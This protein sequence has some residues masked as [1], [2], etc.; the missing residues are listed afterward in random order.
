MVSTLVGDSIVTATRKL[1]DDLELQEYLS[2]TTALHGLTRTAIKFAEI[3]DGREVGHSVR[4]I[5]AQYGSDYL[6]VIGVAASVAAVIKVLSIAIKRMAEAS[7][8]PAERRKL[9]AEGRKVDAEARKVNAEAAA[10]EQKNLRREM[11]MR[12]NALSGPGAQE[13]AF[14]QLIAELEAAGYHQAARELGDRGL[15]GY[16]NLI[17][18]ARFLA[19]WDI[20]IIVESGSDD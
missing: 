11:Q 15:R 18:D 12:K 2:I 5:R 16:A 20:H 4:L 6:C 10:I 3:E 14:K 17:G 9:D 7:K 8:G 13:L 1:P 19:R